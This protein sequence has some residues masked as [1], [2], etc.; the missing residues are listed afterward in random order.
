MSVNEK[1]L[2]A[3]KLLAT[4]DLM[5]FGIGLMRQ[6]IRRRMPRATADEVNAVMYRWLY[7]QQDDSVTPPGN[8]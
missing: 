3:A 2:L 7:L 1:T 5:D 4:V 8:K 6:N